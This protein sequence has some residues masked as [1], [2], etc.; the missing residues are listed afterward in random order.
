[1]IA[2]EV[3]T[4]IADSMPGREMHRLRAGSKG[5]A[6]NWEHPEYGSAWRVSLQVKAA[7][8]RRLHF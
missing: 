1:M 7:S 3:L 8:A 6:A 2:V 4:G 5:S